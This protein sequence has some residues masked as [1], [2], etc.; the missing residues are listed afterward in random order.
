MIPIDGTVM[1]EIAPRFSGSK[2]ARQAQIIGEVGPVL[3]S[4]LEEY[5]INSRLRIAHFL[6][7]IC[8]E[9]A[10]FRTTE[11]FADGSAYEGRADL[12]NV[13]KGDGPRYK[14]R[15]L[16]QL[17][18]RANYKAYSKAVGVDLESNPERAAEPRLSLRIACEYWKRRKINP[19]CDRDDIIAVTK[20]VNGGK[21]G[22]DDRRNYLAKA[23]A[24]VS[25]IEGHLV[26]GTAPDDGRRVLQRGAKGDAVGELQE[27]LRILGFPIAIDEDFGAAT[28]LAVTKFQ[29]DRKL[30]LDGVVG[31]QTWDAIEAAAKKAKAA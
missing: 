26:S 23:K 17:T 1:L 22:L 18:G 13:K 2:G 19:D 28:E 27:R 10:G 9:A 11:E 29:I 14:G 7:Q 5:E 25:R 12:G 3:Q 6:A 4:T 24:A 8:H 30:T 16:L 20:K 15:G 21:N 31:P